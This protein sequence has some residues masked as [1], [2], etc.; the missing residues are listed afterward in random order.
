MTKDLGHV[1]SRAK[2]HRA[3]NRGEAAIVLKERHL[4][5]GAVVSV[6]AARAFALTKRHGGQDG[7]LIEL[8]RPNIRLV[9][10]KLIIRLI[11]L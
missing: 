8:M 2:T 10:L 3:F 6:N 1:L 11:F 4:G 9:F 7:E 5:F